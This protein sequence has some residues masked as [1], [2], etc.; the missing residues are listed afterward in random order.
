MT[1]CQHPCWKKSH[2]GIGY[3]CRRWPS[4]RFGSRKASGKP[5]S[6]RLK[7]RPA[8]SANTCDWPLS[9]SSACHRRIWLHHPPAKASADGL[10]TKQTSPAKA[11]PH[12]RP[13]SATARWSLPVPSSTRPRHRCA[14]IP[15]PRRSPIR[16]RASRPRSRRWRAA[17]PWRRCGWP[18]KKLGGK[19]QLLRPAEIQPRQRPPFV[20]RSAHHL[21]LQLR[22]QGDGH[23]T[24]FAPWSD[25]A[26][27]SG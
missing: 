2:R 21:Q 16:C 26:G 15:T 25:N 3:V 7:E 24:N 22:L 19:V 20:G 1:L 17:A 9:R 11:L 8:G 13:S 27:P 23:A 18:G 5:C 6:Q 12:P 4:S 10:R 14:A